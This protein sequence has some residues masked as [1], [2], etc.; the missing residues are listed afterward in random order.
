MREHFLEIDSKWIDIPRICRWPL[1]CDTH[2][3][4]SCHELPK[5]KTLER[6]PSMILIDV[7][8]WQLIQVTQHRRY[9]AL[10]YVWGRIPDVLETTKK[11][12]PDLQQTG[13]L[14]SQPWTS[15]LSN[16]VRDA[17]LF[18]R[19]MGEQ[20]LWVDRLC[21][22]QDDDL[23]KTDQLKWM[24]SIYA[25]SYFTVIAVD[26][27][28]ANYGLRG[29]SHTSFPRM[30]N[31]TVLQFS[32]TCSMMQAPVRESQFNMKEWHRRGWTFQER[33][34]SN[35]NIIFFQGRVFWD[36]CQSTW[37]E[38]LADAPDGIAASRAT[39]RD[40]NDRYS[41]DFLR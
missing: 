19:S 23:H 28:D 18:T 29:V 36:C 24:A 40:P 12:F 22:I 17:I 13:A 6:P 4:Q 8:G 2:H 5:W 34:L 15:R 25:C 37:T 16:T 32:Q 38:E 33:C 1:Y 9:V 39:K 41:F 26:G 3:R 30:Y 7:V 35:R 11:N 14:A 21:I 31:Q 10:S 27:A 20:Y